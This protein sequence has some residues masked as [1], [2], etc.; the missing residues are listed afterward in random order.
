MAEQ[1]IFAAMGISGFGKSTKKRTL[2]PSRFDKNKRDEVGNQFNHCSSHINS[3]WA[4]HTS[5]DG[6]EKSGRSL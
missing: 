3:V 2:D 5:P 1:D 4:G 6:A